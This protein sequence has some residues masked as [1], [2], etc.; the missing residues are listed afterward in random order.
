MSVGPGGPASPASPASPVP[1]GTPKSYHRYYYSYRYPTY[2]S[3]P[4]YTTKINIAPSAISVDIIVALG[5]GLIII[6]AVQN[7]QFTSLIDAIW[8]GNIATS[9]RSDA[10]LL[11]S[12]LLFL[13]GLTLFAELSQDTRNVAIVFIIALYIVWSVKNA[14]TLKQWLTNLTKSIN[15]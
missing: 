13:L 5:L 3:Y 12:E 9:F 4:S 6:N 1:S 8:S 11:G 2:V 14:S 15:A 7:G 10:I